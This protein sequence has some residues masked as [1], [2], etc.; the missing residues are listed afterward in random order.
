MQYRIAKER[1]T[2][3]CCIFSQTVAVHATS[4]AIAV[5]LQTIA[6]AN[7]GEGLTCNL[8]SKGWAA[9]GA[10]QGNPVA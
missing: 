6:G 9:D 2:S 3:R 5:L 1:G 7:R 4:A 10:D 8:E